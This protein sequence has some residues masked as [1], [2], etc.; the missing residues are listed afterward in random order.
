[1]HHTCFNVRQKKKKGKKLILAI[2]RTVY[3]LGYI[4][5]LIILRMTPYSYKVGYAYISKFC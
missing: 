1:M 3:E 5:L 2:D 4:R